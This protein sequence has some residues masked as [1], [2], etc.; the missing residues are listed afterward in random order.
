MKNKRTERKLRPSIGLTRHLIG[1]VLCL[2]VIS[3]ICSSAPAQNLFVRDSGVVG[4]SGA[5]YKLTPN[6]VRSIFASGLNGSDGG[7]YGLAFDKAGNLFATNWVSGNVTSGT[8][9]KLSLIHISE[10]TRLLSIS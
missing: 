5:I 9:Y 10:P 1:G 6:G 7:F 4:G 2:A 3:L 8:I